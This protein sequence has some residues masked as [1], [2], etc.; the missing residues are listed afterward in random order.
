MSLTCGIIGLPNAGKSTVFNAL[1]RAGA[2][3]APYPFTT[4]KPNHGIAP[5]P[6]AR[7]ERLAALLRPP[8]VVPATVEFV[9]IA[10]LVKG[11]SQGEGLGNQFLG[12][13][14]TVSALAHVVRLFGGQVA[15]PYG[16][17]DPRRDVG[18]ILTELALADLEQ[19]ERRMDKLARR[20][21]VGDKAAAAELE[22]A[23]GLH[24]ALGRGEAVCAG[25]PGA[26]ELLSAKPVVYVANV[27]EAELKTR[28]LLPQLEAV[29]GG[30]P[31]VVMCADLE[32]EMEALEPAERA[33]LLGSLGL[34]EPG[35]AALIRAAYRALG[36]ITFYTV[37]GAEMRA[38]PLKEGARAPEA[39]GKIH[40]DM[41]RG[42][43]RAEVVGAEA[44][45]AAGGMAEAR[46]RG[47]IRLEG[48]DYVVADGDVVHFRFTV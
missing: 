41:E 43:I 18:I 47:L 34:A 13:V 36:L 9:D 24:E 11:A 19:L 35:G 26:A 5:V 25:A 4:I 45:L 38:W 16:S 33:E 15:H 31:L 22:E 44:L 7:L 32:A 29:V 48:R 39:A 3:T 40:T 17:P 30:A 6:D 46:E 42:F 21:K 28:R 23:R 1:S 12:H 8:K 20:A 10:G 14:R 37:V 2:E 27:D